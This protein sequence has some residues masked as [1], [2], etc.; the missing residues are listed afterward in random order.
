VN[1]IGMKH[2]QLIAACTFAAV[3]LSS[4]AAAQQ[5]REEQRA[6]EQAQKATDL[7]PYVPTPLERQIAR[8]ARILTN[9]PP[10][11]VFFGSV[12]RGG[13]VAFGP[14]FRHDI[15]SVGF[16]DTHAAWSIRNYKRVDA[17]LK[18]REF[19]GGRVGVDA[20]VNWL[21][22]PK[23]KF[24]GTGPDTPAEARTSYDFQAATAGVTGRVQL[25]RLFS[26]GATLDY[27]DIDT[28]PGR[29]GVSIER[30]FTVPS[31]PGL[32]LD[33]TYVRTQT[34]AAFDSR[35]SPGYTTRGGL[36]RVGW[37][38]YDQREDG[39][40]SFQRLDAEVN[41]F[42][43]LLHA[44]WILAFRALASTTSTKSGEYVPYFLMPDLG[45]A[46][47]LR[48]YPSWRF[49]DRN[50]LL[51][52]GEY[53][54]TAGRFVDMALFLDAGKVVPALADLDLSDLHSSFGLGVRFHAPAATMLRVEIARTN[55]D[56]IGLVFAVSPSF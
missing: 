8:G 43:P 21:D 31:T 16:F 4:V 48:G 2:L 49:R 28:A 26:V 1:R 53:R 42:V 32:G 29:S 36:Y 5:T 19:A 44:N 7:H 45:G 9:R 20:H 38:L 15:P 40:F 27:L 56:G 46:N 52:T 11:Y 12:Y 41:Q 23:V 34:F 6:E 33:P 35:Q 17:S 13:A 25:T 22:A 47:E 10:V 37:S 14:G 51:L 30:R 55:T 18:L 24:F 54:W 39:P 50:R 3:A